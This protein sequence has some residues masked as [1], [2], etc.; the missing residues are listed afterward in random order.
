MPT[1]VYGLDYLQAGISEIEPYLLSKSLFWSLGSATGSLP[2]LTLGG[3]LFALQ[4]SR[5][6]NLNPEQQSTLLKYETTINDVRSRWQVAWGRKTQREFLSR[7][8][9]W[10]NFINE[11]LKD[12]DEFAPYYP[13]EVR[14][15]VFLR[16]LAPEMEPPDSA[17][18]ELLNNLDDAL[19][20]VFVPGEFVWDRELEPAFPRET[21][22]YL[23]G[24]PA[25]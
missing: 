13:S 7:L 2:R 19:R 5:R 22:W 9:Q 4:R 10:G 3:M 25:P 14:S 23:W 18:G 12:M 1:F 15:R 8:R 6:K 21:Y 16:L 11:L 24:V 20:S 17:Y